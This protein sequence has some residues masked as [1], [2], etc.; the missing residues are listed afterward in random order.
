MICKFCGLNNADDAAFCSRCG[1]PLRENRPAA[2]AAPSVDLAVDD[3]KKTMRME[4]RPNESP[5]GGMMK[6]DCGYPLLPG[7]QVCPKCHKPVAGASASST[8][9]PIDDAKKTMVITNPAQQVQGADPKATER[10]VT[11]GQ[12]V[13]APKVTQ[14]VSAPDQGYSNPKKTE[15]FQT[16]GAEDTV[17]M[18]RP[19]NQQDAAK[20]TQRF[21]YPGYQQGGVDKR[22]VNIHQMKQESKACEADPMPE[23]QCSLKPIAR[24]GE[25]ATPAKNEYKG[26]N[27]IL[28]RQN[29]DPENPTITSRQQ[30]LLTFENGKWYIEDKS[31]YKTTY[32]RVTKKTEIQ[33]GDIIGLGDREF[34]FTTK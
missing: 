20:K 21:E 19:Y 16:P 4:V 1:S 9:P 18:D 8:T 22:T 14:P 26:G 7:T 12:G 24:I 25:M 3:D 2:P 33:D 5:A 27:V 10:F 31:A 15:R 28:N 23:P 17:G 29:T 34:E 13:S 11:P 30:A 32:I 6:H